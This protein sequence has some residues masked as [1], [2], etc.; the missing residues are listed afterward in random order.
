MF[1]LSVT[2][3]VST[4]HFPGGHDDLY[5]KICFVAGPDWAVTAGQEEGISQIARKGGDG[6]EGPALVWNFPLDITFR[7]TCPFGWPQV[8][9]SVY[10]L[11]SF[12]NEMIRGYGS[13][14]VPLSAGSHSA[15]L[16]IF[17]PESSS[18]LQRMASYFTGR[19]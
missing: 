1:L 3:Q 10:E 7:S 11:D 4:G 9:V 8:V 5:C 17:R 14:H 2:G 16:P 13:C 19:R 12:G 15:R 18:L 6:G